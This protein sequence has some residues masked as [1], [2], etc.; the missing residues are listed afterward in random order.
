WS[1]A[2]K[3]RAADKEALSKS[4][5]AASSA[6][7]LST[8]LK[9]HPQQFGFTVSAASLKSEVF[10]RSRDDVQPIGYVLAT[11]GTDALR[12]ADL[13]DEMEKALRAG[14][15]LAKAGPMMHRTRHGPLNFAKPIENQSKLP[16]SETCLAVYL[17]AKLRHYDL[18]GN[19]RMGAGSRIPRDGRS[20]WNLV[21]Q[22][23]QDAL[24]DASG[25]KSAE[26]KAAKLLAR[27]PDLEIWDY[28]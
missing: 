24:N 16:D 1:E 9:R 2:N 22:W 5:T 28:G 19:W 25:I 23:V 14:E 21:E 13:L 20:R 3:T 10:L 4:K 17:V 6:R 11:N 12:L 26:A 15:V 18:T 27:H 7:Q 8:I